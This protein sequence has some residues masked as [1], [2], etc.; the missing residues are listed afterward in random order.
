MLAPGGDD[1]LVGGAGRDRARRAGRAGPGNWNCTGP[2]GC[3]ASHSTKASGNGFDGV[4]Q[5]Q[6]GGDGLFD[7]AFLLGDVDRDADQV[8]A[9][10]AR[11][12]AP[13]RSA[14]AARPNCRWRDACG[15]HGRWRGLGIGE[16]GGELIEVDV[17]GMHERVDLAEGHQIVLRVEPENG[18]HRMRPEDAAAREVPVPQAAAAA[19]ERGVDAAAHRV[20][21]QVGFARARR[22]P[23]EREAEDQQH[24]AG[25]RRQRDG[26][27]GV[28]A[29]GR[30]RVRLALDDAQLPVRRF[31]VAHRRQ[32]PRC[33]RR[34]RFRGHRRLRRE[35]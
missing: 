20:V 5:A 7:Q 10:L 12:G 17:V 24:E 21:D 11:S 3:S 9:G 26:Q 1:V 33:R 30:E 14:P 6:V 16:L 27:R 8:Q 34:A 19:I 23:V 4:A 15:R 28:G 22:L 18:E 2:G 32:A 29:P 31:Q 25:G 13:A 35:W